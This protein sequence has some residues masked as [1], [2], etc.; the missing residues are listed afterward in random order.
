V[1]DGDPAT[2]CD[3]GNPCT[4]DVV[5]GM[6][7]KHEIIGT[8]APCSDDKLMQCWGGECCPVTPWICKVEGEQGE[9]AK[10]SV[11]FESKCWIACDENPRACTATEFPT[12]VTKTVGSVSIQVCE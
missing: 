9:C 8:G 7:C 12:C 1:S 4:V 5:D 10:G 3:D 11:C 2:G 6:N